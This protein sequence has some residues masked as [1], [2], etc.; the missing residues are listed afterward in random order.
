M[1][2]QESRFFDQNVGVEVELGL[3]NIAILTAPILF[4]TSRSLLWR[5]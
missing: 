1:A 3:E 2:D 4:C 5:L